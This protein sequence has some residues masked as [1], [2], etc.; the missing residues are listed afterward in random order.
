MHIPIKEKGIYRLSTGESVEFNEEF[1]NDQ[2]A[3]ISTLREEGKIKN[4]ESY[5][6]RKDRI[7]VPFEQNIFCL[8]NGKGDIVAVV[9][10][11]R[12]VTERRTK[13]KEVQESRDFLENVFK[14][15]LDGIMITSKGIITM[16]NEALEKMLGY[17]GSFVKKLKA[18]EL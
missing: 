12:D 18:V 4:R 2:K 10:L 3:M 1:F 14:T 17:F 15:S 16:V 13:E 8:Y 6:I 5:F 9:G 7:V 11:L